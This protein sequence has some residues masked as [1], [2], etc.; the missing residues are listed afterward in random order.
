MAIVNLP[1]GVQCDPRLGLFICDL[2]DIKN[3]DIKISSTRKWEYV[4]II[5]Y[6]I[7]LKK[8][9]KIAEND[10]DIE[11]TPVNPNI[12]AMIEQLV[13]KLQEVNGSVSTEKNIIEVLEYVRKKQ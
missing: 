1:W 7:D 13:L 5:A 11:D 6:P 3:Q 12:Y 9:I 2:N 10:S 8:L 4:D